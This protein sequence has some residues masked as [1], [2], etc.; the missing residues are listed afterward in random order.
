MTAELSPFQPPV[1]GDRS[2][3]PDAPVFI[4]GADLTALV[5][6]DAAIELVDGA[7]RKLSAGD[8]S[9]PQRWAIPVAGAAPAA[10]PRA[11]IDRP[12]RVVRWHRGDAA[13]CHAGRETRR[14]RLGLHASRT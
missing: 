10:K 4:S 13:A 8:V 11:G 6:L 2:R 3:S 14:S 7:M 1:T 5:S 12:G 9:A